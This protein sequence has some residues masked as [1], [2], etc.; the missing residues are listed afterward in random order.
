MD[1]R[2]MLQ[3]GLGALI[4]SAAV[5]LGVPP[6]DDLASR[7]GP[8]QE[9]LDLYKGYLLNG[10]TAFLKHNPKLASPVDTWTQ[11]RGVARL[12]H[13]GRLVLIPNREVEHEITIEVPNR[14]YWR[15]F[16]PV[17]YG[18]N[19]LPIADRWVDTR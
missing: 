17:I 8:T 16:A 19:Q 5:S 6:T 7:E 14:F 2:Q 1:R 15:L 13:D 18:I 11:R 12:Y 4:G 10:P 3:S 9:D